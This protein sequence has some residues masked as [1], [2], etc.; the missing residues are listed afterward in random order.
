[1]ERLFTSGKLALAGEAADAASH[2]WSTVNA[3]AGDR[4]RLEKARIALYQGHSRDVLDLL[5]EPLHTAV[6]QEA[7]LKR[8]LYQSLALV[9]TGKV[10]E[11]QSVIQFAER[12]K[13]EPALEME[14][15]STAGSIALDLDQTARADRLFRRSLL[16]AQQGDHAFLSMQLFGNLGVIAL[17]GEHYDAAAGLFS[18][19]A[20]L[21]ASLGAKLAREKYLGNLG[22]SLYGTGDYRKALFQF[23]LA[24]DEAKLLDAD[25]DLIAWQVNESL[26]E[27]HLRRP[28][29]AR[30]DVQ[31]AL[32][33][34]E[35]IGNQEMI[36]DA[37]L[38]LGFL[39]AHDQPASALQHA[40]QALSV[41]RARGDRPEQLSARVLRATLL[42]ENGRENEGRHELLTLARQ[43]DLLP[44]FRWRVEDELGCAA[45][46]RHEMRQA[47]LWFRRSLATYGRQR[48]TLRTLD[49]QLPFQENASDLL[50]HYLDH[51]IAN[52]QE[53]QALQVLD[54][55][56]ARSLVAAGTGTERAPSGAVPA[57]ALARRLGGAVLVYRI[58]PLRSYLWAFSAHGRA[59]YSLPGSTVLYALEKQH[60]AAILASRDLQGGSGQ[61][62]R[63][64]FELLVAPALS[65]IGKSDRVFLLTG[66]ALADL[67][68]ESLLTGEPQSHFWIEDVAVTNARSLW[69]LA[70]DARSPQRSRGSP[71]TLLLLGSPSVPGDLYPV[72]SHAD[73]EM[74][75][76][77]A[78]FA[79]G[80]RAVLA[81]AQATPAA[82]RAAHPGGYAYLHFVSHGEADDLEPLHSAILLQGSAAQPDQFRLS[83]EAIAAEPLHAELVTLSACYG[84]GARTYSGEGLVGLAWAFQRAGARHVIGALWEVSDAAAPELMDRLYSG[85]ALG[86]PPDRALRAAKLALLHGTGVSRKPYYWASFMLY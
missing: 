66:E 68:F 59:F 46:A 72:L 47:D 13:V 86:L 32:G 76:V 15:L 6:D 2:R 49:Y 3:P 35:A 60:Q 34:A 57:Q 80:A 40:E 11:A 84:A 58:G 50:N 81:G 12:Q 7:Q 62:G 24:A 29:A 51:L 52:G 41:A 69:R 54:A 71:H 26:C 38:S 67:N 20:D 22:F 55:S 9:R 61:A 64:L 36:G 23:K 48:E 44:S 45:E 5:R 82:Y 53:W 63:T 56:R 17:R 70:Q 85:L 25:I 8:T 14:V 83:S 27:F 18:R 30:A 65:V 10:E 16:L 79:A 78:H 77:A 75:R 1:M 28:D 73:E 37:H 19:A 31:E 74:N 33:G 42:T 39:L 21:A 43:R 4:F